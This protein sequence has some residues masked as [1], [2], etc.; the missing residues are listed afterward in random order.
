M[1]QKLTKQSESLLLKLQNI[2]MHEES[3]LEKE[4]DVHFFFSLNVSKI[5]INVI[6][7][8]ISW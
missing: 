1:K 3:L 5:L 6:K 8:H 4:M 7:I 2:E